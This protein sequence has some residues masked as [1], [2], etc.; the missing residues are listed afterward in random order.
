MNDPVNSMGLSKFADSLSA[1]A[2][3]QA[4]HRELVDTRAD[5]PHGAIRHREMTS[6]RME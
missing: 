2:R 6:A 5:K 3:D 4:G 1:V